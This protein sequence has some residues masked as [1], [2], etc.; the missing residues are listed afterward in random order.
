LPP[1]CLG[2][3][4]P[5]LRQRRDPSAERFGDPLLEARITERPTAIRR[6]AQA[7]DEALVERGAKQVPV[8]L[9]PLGRRSAEPV[10]ELVSGQQRIGGAL[11]VGAIARPAIVAR[12]PAM[13]A[14]T[15]LSSM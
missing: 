4:W 14:R 2:L 5:A 11:C 6:R 10:V 3:G 13:R 15:G 12:L 7:I 8:L 1:L 9:L